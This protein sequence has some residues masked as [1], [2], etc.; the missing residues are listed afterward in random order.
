MPFGTRAFLRLPA[1]MI[2]NTNDD[3]HPHEDDDLVDAEW[4]RR[5]LDEVAD[6]RELDR[7]DVDHWANVSLLPGIG[8]RDGNGERG[9]DVVA[10]PRQETELGD[11]ERDRERREVD[12]RLVLHEHHDER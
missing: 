7:E 12:P 1:Y 11:E 8:F 6:R 3:R 2:P 9:R 5:P 4:S 10:L